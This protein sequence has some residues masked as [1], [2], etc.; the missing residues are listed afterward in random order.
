M[1][2]EPDMIDIRRT[3]PDDADTLARLAG[4]LN[5]HF[6]V[7]EP[8]FEGRVI[9]PLLAGGDPFMF[10][11][12]A[13]TDGEAIGYALCQKFFDTDTGT[14]ATW[15][16]DL[17]VEPD[18]RAGGLGRRLIA[19]VAAD[20]LAKDQRCVGL[21][22]YRDNP[23]RRLYDRIGAALSPEALVYELRDDNLDSLAREAQL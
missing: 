21:A 7:E 5:R 2:W 14:M 10:G 23:A 13:E 8:P 1:A 16:L 9:V 19:Q 12:L 20:A 11:Y 17:Y 18:F 4:A 3:R 15:L 22:V 6:G